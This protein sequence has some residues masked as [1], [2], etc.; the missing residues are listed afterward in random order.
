MMTESR[1]ELYEL[2]QKPSFLKA[3]GSDVNI[4]TVVWMLRRRLAHHTAEPD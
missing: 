4:A 3:G 1:T 2:A